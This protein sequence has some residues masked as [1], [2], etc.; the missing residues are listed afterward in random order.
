MTKLS[1]YTVSPWRRPMTI[2]PSWLYI[3]STKPYN[4]F[5][6][7]SHDTCSATAFL[8]ANEPPWVALASIQARHHQ[9]SLLSHLP[10]WLTVSIL[11][12]TLAGSSRSSILVPL[13]ETKSFEWGNYLNQIW[14]QNFNSYLVL[15]Q[16]NLII[17]DYRHIQIRKFPNLKR[18][19]NW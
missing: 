6:V 5:I 10:T 11:P 4:P 8:A 17:G 19:H 15:S 2:E 1:S 13:L 9:Q 7:T 18:A 14:I 12:L 3:A 16:S